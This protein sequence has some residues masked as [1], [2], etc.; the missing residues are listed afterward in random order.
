[1]DHFLK[2]K[3]HQRE[4]EAAFGSELE[5]QPEQDKDQGTLMHFIE[6][7]DASNRATWPEQH[8]LIAKKVA[9]LYRAV[10]PF[11]EQLDTSADE[12]PDE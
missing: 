11:V 4:I 7:N 5:W 6:G 3:D 9:S 10:L 8:A 2:L 12:V 1:M